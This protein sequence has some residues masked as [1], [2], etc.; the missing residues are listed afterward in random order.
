M[1]WLTLSLFSS[2]Q[3]DGFDGRGRI[4]AASDID[5]R[6]P[7]VAWRPERQRPKSVA[8][9]ALMEY[10]DEPL[11][12][13]T[14][15]QD[16]VERQVLLDNVFGLNVMGHVA[17]H[18]RLAIT[19]T[20]PVWF[21]S[22]G[23]DGL[24][25]VGAGDLRIAAP[26]G[27][28]MPNEYNGGFG[29][30]L[31]PFVDAPT[32]T[33]T[34]FLGN[35]GPS[36]GGLAAIGMSGR[37][38][39]VDGNVGYRS[40]PDVR[41]EDGADLQWD[42][43]RGGDQLLTALAGSV[44][45]GRFHALRL[46]GLHRA[47]LADTEVANSQSPA[48]ILLS[49]RGRYKQGLSWTAGVGTGLNGAAGA[50][51]FR[52]FAGLGYTL[53]K[54]PA[55]PEIAWLRVAVVDPDGEPIG[56]AMVE[57]DL[58]EAETGAEGIAGF[59][60]VDIGASLRVVAD[61][62]GYSGNSTM[63]DILQGEN[64]ARLVL[65]PNP[66]VLKVIVTDNEG[67]PVDA[68]IVLDGPKPGDAGLTGDD[69]IG[70]WEV[71]PGEWAVVAT[72]PDLPVGTGSASVPVAG[73]GV[74][75]IVL[76]RPEVEITKNEIVTLDKVHFV[77]DTAT[78]VPESEPI[79]AEVARILAAH[80]EF[81]KVE[82]A[83][84]TDL[85]GTAEYNRDLSARRVQTVKR[86]LVAKGVDADR[87]APKGYGESKPLATGDSEEDHALNRRVQFVILE[88]SDGEGQP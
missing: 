87:L 34:A 79:L 41:Y 76:Q 25:G 35:N 33:R 83:G 88:R 20:V 17:P 53:G 71:P 55:E 59:D 29:L 12:V 66:G 18:E 30:S 80:P 74:V 10:A 24:Q 50:A 36:W 21:T 7:I 32:G 61:A 56:G 51:R 23:A 46:E 86:F 54:P 62:P 8:L 70:S 77:F 42:N 4:V 1:I 2:A 28:A 15:D 82:V 69:G 84:H 14:L 78:L 68:R 22:R 81:V 72:A 37:I 47:A 75:E 45:L 73:V 9:Q 3:S 11:V 49:G 16:V 63:L 85:R 26:I 39:E 40:T 67:S 43:L 48:E 57:A 60:D 13:Y 5:L 58:E 64:Q 65:S 44:H 38:W 52:L 31:I 6:D 27:L 19:A